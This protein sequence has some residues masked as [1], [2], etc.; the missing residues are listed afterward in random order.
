MACTRA[1]APAN[2]RARAAT[3]RYY[4]NTTA[5]TLAC[6][7]FRFCGRFA[8]HPVTSQVEHQRTQRP[9]RLDLKDRCVRLCVCVRARVCEC[10]LVCVRACMCVCAC[11]TVLRRWVGASFQICSLSRKTVWRLSAQDVDWMVAAGADYLK[12]DSCCG[13]Q[14]HATAFTEYGMFRDALNATGK[15]VYFSLCGW[16]EWYAPPDPTVDYA[17]T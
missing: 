12:I 2:V 4:R 10:V 1:A 5:F 3:P 15:P 13:S 9:D 7:P 6:S 11:V 14:D 17:G 8:I 16:E